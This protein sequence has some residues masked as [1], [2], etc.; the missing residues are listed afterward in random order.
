MVAKGVT[1]IIQ[2]LSSAPLISARVDTL[3]PKNTSLTNYQTVQKIVR[4]GSSV[5]VTVSGFTI[6]GETRFKP[7][8]SL[9]NKSE[10]LQVPSVCSVRA[11]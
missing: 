6:W 10:E 9:L 8:A 2:L 1:I 7:G 5:F 11:T 3:T 4:E